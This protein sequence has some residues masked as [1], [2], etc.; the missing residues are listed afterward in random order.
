MGIAFKH[1]TA[2]GHPILKKGKYSLGRMPSVIRSPEIIEARCTKN[3]CTVSMKNCNDVCW[4]ACEADTS[5]DVYNC[6][7][8]GV[9]C[10]S[11]EYYYACVEGNC[12]ESC[13]GDNQCAGDL[14]E[15]CC[16][17][18]TQYVRKC[19]DPGQICDPVNCIYDSDCASGEICCPEG[20]SFWGQ[21]MVSK[22]CG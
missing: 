12:Q 10:S 2:C 14:D 9:D 18:G 21:C 19:S 4:E 7:N 15:I 3:F 11:I 5:L 22:Y 13:T 1:K 8:C 6:G 20:T 16:P 17:P